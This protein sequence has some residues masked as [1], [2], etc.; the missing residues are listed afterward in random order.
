M[1]STSRTVLVVED[2]SVIRMYAVALLEDA[3]FDVL[4]A[5]DS[6]AALAV[7]ADHP[8][9]DVLLTDVRMPGRM[10]GLALIGKVKRDRPEIRAIVVSGNVSAAEALRAGA[11]KFVPK[12]YLAHSIVGAVRAT[13]PPD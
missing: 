5:K 11:V 9:V 3:G 7:L 6:E 8:D 1:T 10:D 12:P 13:M 4:A 2:E